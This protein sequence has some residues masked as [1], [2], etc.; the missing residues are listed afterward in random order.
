[1][2]I[3]LN[4]FVKH[5]V[6]EIDKFFGFHANCIPI[7]KEAMSEVIIG[8]ESFNIGKHSLDVPSRPVVAAV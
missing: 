5:V 3:V 2:V 1:M 4:L 6:E 8:A 7:I